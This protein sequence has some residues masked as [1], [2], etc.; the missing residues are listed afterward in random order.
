MSPLLRWGSFESDDMKTL[1]EPQHLKRWT[2]PRDYAGAHWTDYYSFLG[3]H[4]D[5]SA[6]ERA[7]FD[8]GLKA[9]GGE[10]THPTKTDS[11]DADCALSLVRVVRENH[12][13]VGWVEWIA[14]HQ[15]A[16]EALQKADDIK[17]KL[18]DYPVVDEDL[19]SLYE[20]EEADEVWLNCYRPA[21]RVKWIR[22]HRSQFEFHDF[23]DMIGCI[24][25]HYFSGYASELLG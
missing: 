16:T 9:I 14:I 23:A 4:R 5:S 6:L 18:E 12:W 8:A 24:R 13:A 3:R 11:E 7:N 19:F 10:Q 17:G 15:T 1:F 25:G 20:S 22:E 21:E 2:L